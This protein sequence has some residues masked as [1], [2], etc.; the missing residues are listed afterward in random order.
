MRECWRASCVKRYCRGP[1]GSCRCWRRGEGDGIDPGVLAGKWDLQ[2]EGGGR[3]FSAAGG[4]T[5]C[6]TGGKMQGAPRSYSSYHASFKSL[7]LHPLF[8]TFIHTNI[9][10]PLSSAACRGHG[11]CVA[12]VARPGGQQRGVGAVPQAAVHR[13][14]RG[15]TAGGPWD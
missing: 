1:S 11:Q 3:K 6:F 10:I 8:R 15:V 14:R 13:G 12:K 5:R 2:V 9:I 4:M 7:V